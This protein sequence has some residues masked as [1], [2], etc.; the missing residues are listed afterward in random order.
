MDAWD[1]KKCIPCRGDLPPLTSAEIARYLKEVPDW[2]LATDEPRR[3][4]RDFK[5]K[6][7]KAALAFVNRVGALAETEGHHPN[8]TLHSWN[9]VRIELYT[10]K[11]NGLHENDFVMAAKI[12]TLQR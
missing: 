6:D 11:I 4:R 8:M 12:N 3:I 10:H 7:F 5:F 9:Q 1:E 2:S